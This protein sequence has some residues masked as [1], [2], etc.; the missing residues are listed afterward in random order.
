MEYTVKDSMLCFVIKDLW[1]YHVSSDEANVVDVA[2]DDT[3]KLCAVNI[4]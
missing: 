1:R 2:E 4:K 3:K